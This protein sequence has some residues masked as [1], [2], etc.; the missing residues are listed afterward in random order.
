MGILSPPPDRHALARKRLRILV[1]GAVQGVG[2]RPFVHQRATALGLAG[3]VG[4]SSDGVTVEVEGDASGLAALIETIRESPPTNATI[5]AIEIQEIEPCG[6]SVFA[7]RPSE[8]T[9]N[10]SAQVLPDL[11]TCPDCLAELFDPSDRRHRYPFINCT[12]CGPRYSIIEDIPYDRARTSMRHFPMCAA[13]QAEYEDPTNRRFHAEPNA[14]AACG[15]HLALWDAEGRTLA[16]DDSA[17]LAAATALRAGQIVA[18]K[19]IG[20]FHLLVDARDEAAVRRLRARKRRADKPFAVMFPSLSGLAASCRIGPIEEVLLCGPARPIVLL[21]R[22]GSLV[23]DAVAPGN[24]WLGALLPYAP[25]HQLLMRE[26]GFPVVATSG[27]VTDEPIVTDECEARNR[28]AGIADLFLVHDRQIVRP[29]DDSVVRIVCGREL[30]L[31]RSRGYAPAPI[32]VDRMPAGI[33]ALG[34]HLKTTI[35]LSSAGGVV[36]SQHIGGL[37]TVAACA[38]H[39]RTIAD[40]ARLYGEAPKVAV[41]DLHPDY[42]SSRTAEGLGLPVIAVQHHVAHVVACMAE[43]GIAPPVLGVAWDGTGYGPD[44]TIWGGE[45]LLVTE[46]A[47]R[48]VGH[49]RP[50]RLPGGDAAAREPRRAALGLLAEAIGEEAFAMTNLAPVAACSP[51]ERRVLRTM[52]ARGINAPVTSSAGRLF[53]AFAAICG[54]RQCASYEGQAAAELEWAAEGHATGRRY[55]FPVRDAI[56][57]EAPLVVDWQPAL[58]AA[59]IDLAAGTAPGA[60]SAALHNGLAGAIAAVAVRIGQ[61]R[62]VLSGGCFQNA[63]LTEATV[64][65]LREAGCE[66]VWHRRVPPNDGGIALGQA[67]WAALTEQ[68]RRMSCA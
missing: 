38:A 9:G 33:V 45:F 18:L 36:L 64:A 37:A 62:I 4:N 13:C 14:C 7:I 49:L 30:M 23:A 51:T 61:R 34:G 15:P 11:A 6:G 32:A 17:L 50:F 46:K 41:R 1:R 5:A 53:D 55:E 44:G 59:L 19:G 68:R 60:V 56:E 58:Q 26:L 48:R 65:A 39:L 8:T 28:L 16:R 12:Q 47:W 35:A 22:T 3:W 63:R 25:I 2:F 31:R 42:A 52:L 67:A 54:L 66:P 21:R 29:V 20:G 27:N 10:R 24:P 57:S 40:T 43:H